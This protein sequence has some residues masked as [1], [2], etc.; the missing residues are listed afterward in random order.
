MKV[1]TRSSDAPKHLYLLYCVRRPSDGQEQ[2]SLLGVY[3]TRAKAVDGKRRLRR[4]TKVTPTRFQIGEVEMDKD[5]WVA[6]YVTE[7]RARIGG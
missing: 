5:Y 6:G 3:S 7:N 1:R 2:M 4:S